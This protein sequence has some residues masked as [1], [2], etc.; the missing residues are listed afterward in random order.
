VNESKQEYESS[1]SLSGK[2]SDM[3]LSEIHE[4]IDS[5]HYSDTGNCHNDLQNLKMAQQ[6][7]KSMINVWPVEKS[8]KSNFEIFTPIYTENSVVDPMQVSSRRILTDQSVINE[9]AFIKNLSSQEK[10]HDKKHSMVRNS[11]MPPGQKRQ[12]P[13]LV[14]SLSR[15]GSNRASM[16]EILSSKQILTDGNASEAPSFARK[17]SRMYFDSERK[18]KNTILYQQEKCTTLGHGHEHKKH[19]LPQ[20]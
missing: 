18:R 10:L 5:V 4:E 20:Y 15:T 8:D 6:L 2:K 16:R 11:L 14:Q 3:Q 17:G 19:V 13:L 1:G 12:F 9:G 7:R